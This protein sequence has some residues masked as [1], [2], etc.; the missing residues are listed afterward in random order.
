MEKA[1]RYIA[2]A[3]L[4]ETAERYEDMQEVRGLSKYIYKNCNY[5]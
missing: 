4:A 3:K 5:I 2:I 1:D